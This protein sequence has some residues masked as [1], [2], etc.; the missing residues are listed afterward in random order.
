[1]PKRVS[2]ITLGGIPSEIQGS[3]R[4]RK[5]VCRGFW[6]INMVSSIDPTQWQWGTSTAVIIIAFVET[7]NAMAWPHT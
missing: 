7:L 3:Y 1:M 4:R 2:D 5:L 6:C